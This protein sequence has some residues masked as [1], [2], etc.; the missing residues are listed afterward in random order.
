MRLVSEALARQR[1]K[2]FTFC[3]RIRD[4]LNRGSA[5]SHP[6][7]GSG[8][9]SVSEARTRQRINTLTGCQ[10]I[11][12]GFGQGGLSSTEDEDTH[13]LSGIRDGFGQ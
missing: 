3:Q 8:T 2:T 10:G 6:V 5:C 11:R 4:E 12:D 13:I 9:R 7:K 1:I